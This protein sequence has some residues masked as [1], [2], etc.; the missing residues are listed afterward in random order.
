MKTPTSYILIS[1]LAATYIVKKSKRQDEK[2]KD[3]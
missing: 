3:T 1:N 2:K